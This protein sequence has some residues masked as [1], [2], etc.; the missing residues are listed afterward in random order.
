MYSMVVFIF[1]FI[2][3]C[4]LAVKEV[5]FIETRTVYIFC[6]HTYVE[7]IWIVGYD[8]T[9]CLLYGLKY[10]FFSQKKLH[11]NRWD[12]LC[13]CLR[14]TKVHAVTLSTTPF[15]NEISIFRQSLTKILR[16]QRKCSPRSPNSMLAYIWW[17]TSLSFLINTDLGEWGLDLRKRRWI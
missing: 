11:R 15:R 17:P 3:F 1:S 9:K 14:L 13:A 7:Y 8:S 5:D 4:V 6:F 12:M 16:P 2:I 10:C